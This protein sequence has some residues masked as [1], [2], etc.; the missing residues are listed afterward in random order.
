MIEGESPFQFNPALKAVVEGK[1][2]FQTNPIL[3]S[4]LEGKKPYQ[5]SALSKFR[6]LPSLGLSARNR[7][8]VYRM[9]TH[10]SP[11]FRSLIK[12]VTTYGPVV[13]TPEEFETAP[14]P[15]PPT[16][17][18]PSPPADCATAFPARRLR[19]RLPRPP[20][21]CPT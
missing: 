21:T 4:I 3:R 14:P 18:P 15:P 12:G 8:N 10:Q 7:L 13:V 1:S 2:P 16:A 5:T 6:E 9:P 20:T 19:H 11:A 17:P